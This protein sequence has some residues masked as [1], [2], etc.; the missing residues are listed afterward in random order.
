M[1][2]TTYKLE[3]TEQFWPNVRLAVKYGLS[4]SAALAALTTTPAEMLGMPGQLGRIANGYQADI[5]IA[6]GDLFKD[7]EIVATWTR[8][9]EH[10]FKPINDPDFTGEYALDLAGEKLQLQISKA[11]GALEAKLVAGDKNVKVDSFN[12]DKQQLQFSAALNE[13]SKTKGVAQFS[14]VLSG[15]QLFGDVRMPNGQQLKITASRKAMPAAADER[16]R[17]HAK[18]SVET[19]LP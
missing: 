18:V 8:G 15:Q 13:V 12:I 2:L 14:G 7:G 16:K 3:K 10:A 5:V 11:D 1:A 9:Q 4:E 6:N 19:D 17:R